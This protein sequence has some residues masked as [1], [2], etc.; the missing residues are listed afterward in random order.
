MNTAFDSLR[1]IAGFWAAL[2]LALLPAPAAAQQVDYNRDVLPVLSARCFQCHGPDAAARKAKLRLD[3]RSGAL[4]Q[5]DGDPAVVPGHPDK[6]AL[7]ARIIRDAKAGRMPPVKT[8]AGLTPQ[9]IA[10]LVQWIEEGAPYAEHWA[11][12]PPTAGFLPLVPPIFTL[13]N[14]SEEA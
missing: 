9:Q 5:R 13:S 2:S 10:L 14:C 6:S 8:G 11:F 12:V 3:V 1:G 7:V 4:A